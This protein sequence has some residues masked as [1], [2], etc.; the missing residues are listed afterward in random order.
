MGVESELHLVFFSI[1]LNSAQSIVKDGD[2]T[3]ETSTSSDTVDI[4]I[5]DNGEGMTKY[6][7]KKITEPFYTTK[8]PGKGTGLGLSIAYAIIKYHNGSIDFQS[9]K[10]KGTQVTLTFPIITQL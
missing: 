6:E 9:E 10:N 1:F 7:L 2:I 8:E 4:I 3:I 5:S